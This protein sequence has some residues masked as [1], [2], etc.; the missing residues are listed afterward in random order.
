MLDGGMI[1][2]RTRTG[3]QAA[4]DH[5]RSIALDAED[6]TFIGSEEALVARLGCSRGTVR[7][8]ARLLEREGLLRVKRGIN[9]GYFVSRPDAGT[10]EASVSAYLET[11]D[12]DT[13]DVTVLASALWVEVMRKAARVGRADAQALAARFRPK[14]NRLKPGASFAEIL[15]LEQECRTEIFKLTRSGYIE[16]IFEIN[17]TFASRKFPPASEEIAE[18]DHQEFVRAWKESKLLELSAI[19]DGD[20]ELATMAARYSRKIWHRRV[21][22]RRAGGADDTRLE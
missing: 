22:A 15:R 16:L 11:L 5:L 12:M 20:I 9:G 6:G 1:K 2:P 4:A 8:L 19:Q 10:I 14:V 18:T 7:Q 3:L 13:Q 21:W 17:S